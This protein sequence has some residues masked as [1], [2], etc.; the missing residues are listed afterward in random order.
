[1]SL[2]SG[3]LKKTPSTGLGYHVRSSSI[4]A[5]SWGSGQATQTTGAAEGQCLLL[6]ASFGFLLRDSHFIILSDIS[7]QRPGL[8]SFFPAVLAAGV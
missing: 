1:M 6:K 4:T 7:A 5:E 8:V 2:T 3:Y